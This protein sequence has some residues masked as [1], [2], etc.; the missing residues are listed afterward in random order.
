MNHSTSDQSL[1]LESDEGEDERKNLYEDEEDDGT[2]SD[3]SDTYN[4]NQHDHQSKPSSYS[5]AW[6]KSYR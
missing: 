4:R 5:T 6:P 1:Y 3:T 2:L